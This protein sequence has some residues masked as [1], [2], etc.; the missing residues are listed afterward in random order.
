MPL[1]DGEDLVEHLLTREDPVDEVRAVE[2]AD[3]DGRVAQVQLLN[4]VAPDRLGGRRGQ[5][6]ERRLREAVAQGGELAV[7]GPKIVPP[8]ADAVGLVDGERAGADLA[9]E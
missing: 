2:M 9:E 8:V 7:L 5:G 3:Q 1:E 4:N 6:V